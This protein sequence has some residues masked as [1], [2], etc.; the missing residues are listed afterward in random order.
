M[1]KEAVERKVKGRE[2]V[3]VQYLAGVKFHK[4]GDKSVV[5]ALIADKLEKAKKAKIVKE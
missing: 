1:A 4:A 5:H 3:T 2:P